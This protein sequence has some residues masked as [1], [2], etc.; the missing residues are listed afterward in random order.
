MEHSLTQKYDL[1]STRFSINNLTISNRN[2]DA[3]AKVA[4]AVLDGN[5]KDIIK[6][7]TASKEVISFAAVRLVKLNFKNLL[8]DICKNASPIDNYIECIF[9][10]CCDN[11]STKEKNNVRFASFTL[12]TIL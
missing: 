4:V 6:A 10:I 5:R 7:F 1:F 8:M 2:I 11:N 9:N 3:I 12:T